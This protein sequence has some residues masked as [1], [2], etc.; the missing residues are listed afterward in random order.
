[1]TAPLRVIFMGSP[2]FAVPV[3]EAVAASHRV[4]AAVTQPDRPA[5]R[6][7]KLR[8][9]P[10]KEL[11]LRLDVPVLQPT[12]IKTGALQRELAALSA[13]VAVVA[14]YGRILPPAI[15][16]HTG[17]RNQR[18]NHYGSHQNPRDRPL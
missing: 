17:N 14:A 4:V 6:G 10:V 3:L 13:D 2:D 16:R 8:P 1:M 7:R 18:H 12:R 5:G 11:A 15:L 9:P